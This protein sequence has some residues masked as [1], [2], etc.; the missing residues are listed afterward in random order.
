MDNVDEMYNAFQITEK[1]KSSF[2]KYSDAFSS[3][4]NDTE[5]YT[6]KTVIIDESGETIKSGEDQHA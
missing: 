6:I 1:D 5:S 2:Q 4:S 3:K